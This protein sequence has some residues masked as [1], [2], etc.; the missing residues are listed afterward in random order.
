[1]SMDRETPA[2]PAADFWS[3][4]RAKVQDEEQALSEAEQAEVHAQAQAAQEARPDAEILEELD[5]PL[6]EDMTSPEQVR[7][8]LASA[9]PAR[10]RQRA[11]R[12]LWRL[13]PLLAN[14]DGLV[15]YGGDF[16]D[17][18]LVIENMQTA[19][20]VGR[21]MLKAFEQPE[22][23]AA[24]AGETAEDAVEMTGGVDVAEVEMVGAHESVGD[25]A[26]AEVATTGQSD[27][28][29]APSFDPEPEHGAPAPRRMR[30]RFD[31]PNLD[32]PKDASQGEQ[33]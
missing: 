4:R 7:K 21:G 29:T 33:V 30:F 2:K 12:R 5:L 27:P 14:V 9:A 19:Y 3:R 10:L 11:L 13:N 22:E 25:P 8:L 23:E 18:A 31:A 28:A 20:Q 24:D 17:A 6:P 32:A 15:D 16:T 26:Q 1:M